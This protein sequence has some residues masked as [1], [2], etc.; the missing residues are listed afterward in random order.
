MIILKIIFWFLVSLCLI[1]LLGFAALGAL[2]V[3]SCAAIAA[4]EHRGGWE[5]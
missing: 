2:V 3:I 1:V 4:H 5:D